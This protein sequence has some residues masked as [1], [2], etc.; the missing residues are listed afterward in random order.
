MVLGGIGMTPCGGFVQAG[1]DMV[2][3]ESA[4]TEHAPRLWRR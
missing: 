3:Y 2:I 1:W 4:K